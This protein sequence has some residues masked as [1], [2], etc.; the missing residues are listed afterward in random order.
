MLEAGI[1][2]KLIFSLTWQL[3]LSAGT[4]AGQSAGA[5]A[6][7]LFMRP[8]FP[9]NVSIPRKRDSGQSHIAFDDLVLQSCS[10]TL[11]HSPRPSNHKALPRFKGRKNR[12][13]L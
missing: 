10:I 11:P 9:H 3:T 4:S 8:G 2:W 6:R 5:L 7:G 12:L 1:I 13:T